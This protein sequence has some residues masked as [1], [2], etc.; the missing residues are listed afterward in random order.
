MIPAAESAIPERPLVGALMVVWRGRWIIALG[1]VLGVIYGVYKVST[2]E[3]VYRSSSTIY[4]TPPPTVFTSMF[5]NPNDTSGYLYTQCEII[6]STAMLTKALSFKGV[7]E[8]ECLRNSDNPVGYLKNCVFAGPEKEGSLITVWMVS[9]N[10]ED[11]ATIVNGVVGAYLAYQ[12]EQHQSMSS[13]V[14][15]IIKDQVSEQE[16]AL[17]DIEGRITQFRKKHPQLALDKQTQGVSRYDLELSE[18]ENQA[19]LFGL[20]VQQARGCVDDPFEMKHLVDNVNKETNMTADTEP[21]VDPA[22][23]AKIKE[24]QR[25]LKEM[26]HGAIHNGRYEALKTEVQTEQTEFTQAKLDASQRYMKYLNARLS[27]ATLKQD[28]CRAAVAK[29]REGEANLNADQADYDSLV[30]QK[31]QTEHALDMLYQK[32][33]SVGDGGGDF[34]PLTASVLEPARPAQESEGARRSSTLMINFIGGIML[35]LGGALLLEMLEQRLRSVEEVTKFLAPPVLGSVPHILP[36][37]GPGNRGRS[38]GSWAR[39]LQSVL[40]F[41]GASYWRSA[42]NLKQSGQV[43]HLQ[44]RCDVAEAYRSIRTAIFFGLAGQPAKTIL[45]TSPASGDGKTTLASNLAISIAQTGR[46]V[47]LIDA[48]CWHPAQSEVFEIPE[49]AGLTDI[50]LGKA[51][52]KDV[53]KKTDIIGLD[54][55]PCGK[56]PENPAEM[57]GGQTWTDLLAFTTAHYDQVI[58]DSPPVVPITDARVLAASCEATILVLRAEKSTRRQADEAFEALVS[59]GATVLGLVV[60]DVVRRAN[61]RSYQYY[62]YA[63]ARGSRRWEPVREG[64]NGEVSSSVHHGHG[65]GNGSGSGSG[66]IKQLPGT[67]IESDATFDVDRG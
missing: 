9:R 8:T 60:N 4:L 47:L 7:A 10:A 65:N 28:A 62:Q 23:L 38:R 13:Q 56:I 67:I 53:V 26:E 50:L 43:M 40:T 2:F 52:F 1:M 6:H 5:V 30:N 32:L 45:V 16:T 61:G 49:G 42:E 29:Q 11:S 55:L 48:D 63:D 21:V 17:K 34:T 51:V 36:K 25:S 22:L 27:E 66:E 14:N 35:G 64:I 20:A 58:I 19:F 39:Y 31:Q 12:T 24:T 57:L 18:A 54:L 41:R 33:K 15:K 3:P 37:P 44:P 46:H 59:V